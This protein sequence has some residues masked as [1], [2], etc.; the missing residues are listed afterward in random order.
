MSYRLGSDN[1]LQSLQTS[2]N[3]LGYLLKVA[4]IFQAI[5]HIVELTPI[6]HVNG[7]VVVKEGA[8]GLCTFY[9]FFD[10]IAV[11]MCNVAIIWIML[12]M[13]WIANKL[14]TSTVQSVANNK[15]SIKTELIG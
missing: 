1:P 10:Q 4:D 6:E 14:R 11:W 7:E 5:T 13:L 2:H 12:Y 9:G 3:P 15:V 8:K